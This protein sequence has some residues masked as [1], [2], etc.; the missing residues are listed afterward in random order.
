L[1]HKDRGDSSSPPNPACALALLSQLWVAHNDCDL[2]EQ[3]KENSCS[4]SLFRRS[5]HDPVWNGG[6]RQ[7]HLL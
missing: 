1:T 5:T 3:Q 4:D 6:Y 7:R 2:R